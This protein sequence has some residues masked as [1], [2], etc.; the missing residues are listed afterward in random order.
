MRVP[1]GVALVVETVTVEVPDPV[2]E[3][4]LNPTVTPA[5]APRM[6]AD[7]VT[8][9]VKPFA[10]VSEIIVVPGAPPGVRLRV[11]GDA[12]S[13][14]YGFVVD[15]GASAVIMPSPFGVPQPVT[16]SKPVI[17]VNKPVNPGETEEPLGLL[18]LV[19][20]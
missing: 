3:A 15:A 16:M 4:G 5:G 6:F 11:L 14:K 8:V 1:A 9:P 12:D 20:S 19:M 18:P 13:V 10:E 17:A 2:I 7:R